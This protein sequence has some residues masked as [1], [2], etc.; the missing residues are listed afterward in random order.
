MLVVDILQLLGLIALAILI[1]LITTPL[2]LHLLKRFSTFTVHPVS[3]SD[4]SKREIYPPNH[5]HDIGSRRV[6]GEEMYR[7]PIPNLGDKYC[8]KSRYDRPDTDML[9]QPNTTTVDKL[10]NIF[11]RVIAFYRN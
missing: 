1:S 7:N 11:H 2:I 9:E 4:N 8:Y 3:H 10:L 6:N 5:V